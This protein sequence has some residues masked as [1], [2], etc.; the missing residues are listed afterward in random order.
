M[1]EQDFSQLRSGRGVKIE[2]LCALEVA[3]ALPGGVPKGE[4]GL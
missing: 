1:A 3:S 2:R 4:H